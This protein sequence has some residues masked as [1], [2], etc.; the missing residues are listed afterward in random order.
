[1]MSIICMLG[2][3]GGGEGSNGYVD[4]VLQLLISSHITVG[5][6]D[7]LEKENVDDV[8]RLNYIVTTYIQEANK[9]HKLQ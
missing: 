4:S 9:H 2:G 3:S 7:T 1:M 8:L 6:R 5:N